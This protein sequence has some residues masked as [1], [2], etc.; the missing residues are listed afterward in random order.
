MHTPIRRVAVL[1]A[2]TMGGGIA[3][4]VANAGVPVYLLDIVPRELTPEE[5]DQGLTLDDPQVRNRIVHNGLE[6]IKK[7]DP[8]AYFTEDTLDLI[9]IGNFEDD[10]EWIGEADWIV[11][12]V[13]EDLNVKQQVMARVDETCRPDTLVSSNTS[14]IPIHEIG[15]GRS[16]D[17]R[18]HFMGTHFF[19]PPRYM[20]LLEV[21]PMGDTR[22]G[23]VERIRTFAEQILG[24][25]VV[26]AKDT[27]NF[28]ANRIGTFSGQYR[29][30]YALEHGF[31]VEEV[32]R[33]TGP[34]IG[35]PKTATFRLADFVGIDV[36]TYVAK[37]LYDAVP[38]DEMRDYFR[39][40]EPMQRM[41]DRGWLG[42]KAGQGFYEKHPEAEGK[43]KYWP[44]DLETLEYAPPEK[45]RFDVVGEVRTIDDWGERF[46]KIFAR[47]DDDRAARFITDTTLATLTYA[48]RRV[49]EIADRI[50]DVD[51]S[52]R[53]GF[54]TEW[55][56][57]EQ[58]DLV[59]VTHVVELAEKYGHPVAGWVTEMLDAGYESFYRWDA[60]D[61]IAYYDLE[62]KDYRPVEDDPR[63]VNVNSLKRAGR[64]VE[65]NSSASL[66]D[67]DDGVLLFE[68]HAKMNALDE[69][70]VTMGYTALDY[71]E[72]DEWNGLVIAN[73]GQN[74]CAGANIALI[75]MAAKAGQF[76][77]IDAIARRLQDLLM[78]FRFAPKPVVMSPH[79]MALGG[80]AEVVMAGDRIVASAETYIGL[81]ELAVGLI[82]AGG[83]CKEL[84]R[85]VVNPVMQTENADPLP[86]LQKIFEYVAMANV[87][88]S[89]AAARQAGFL[90]PGDHIVMNDRYRI[91]EAKKEVLAMLERGY[92]PPARETARVYAVG[93]RGLGALYT[94]I[95]GYLNGRY[96]SEYDAHLARKLAY[97]MCGGDLSRPQWVP[98]QYI[99]DLEREAFVSL[100]GEE[101][102]HER[103]M[104]MLQTGK[105][106]RN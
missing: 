13:I 27:P 43:D 31:A 4:H 38:D 81:V 69:D 99:L 40:P 63:V 44:I 80:G 42:N 87:A 91:G 78:G 48:S 1:G 102:T 8:Q 7:S 82:P 3:A 39:V 30:H 70:I 2:G 75:G 14:G 16:D 100:C 71:L 20:Y 77:Q 98:E 86:F 47:A 29:V 62:T 106:L 22:P 84:L 67:L 96:V 49:P 54:R 26:I 66:V 6:A 73:Q 9:Q 41:V 5:K 18:A 25:G 64:E 93:Q 32:D 37:N 52:M 56:P 46:R 76:D 55:G 28:I 33:L 58:W 74:F 24:K 12:A 92:V 10:W 105:P 104:H 34:V 61:P 101:K 79:A 45:P 35:N 51:R 11:E 36:W 15:A 83:G 95:Q 23:A 21:I 53:W 85:R 90:G 59:G 60:G 57:F 50:V 97:V 88:R 65:R 72:R 19:N 17:F 103:I 68:F 94:G 89:A